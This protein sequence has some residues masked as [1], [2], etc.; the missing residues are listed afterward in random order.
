MVASRSRAD[1]HGRDTYAE[2]RV[3]VDPGYPNARKARGCSMRWSHFPTPADL[4]P[5]F[6]ADDSAAPQR[7]LVEGTFA[8][9]ACPQVI[10]GRGAAGV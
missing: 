10:R 4:T 1:G 9:P 6:F 8:P 3:G 2:P 7:A 5:W